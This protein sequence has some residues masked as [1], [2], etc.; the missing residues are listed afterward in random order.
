M[1]LKKPS[2]GRLVTITI[3]FYVYPLGLRGSFLCI[4]SVNPNS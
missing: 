2:R 4:N 1:F 3:D